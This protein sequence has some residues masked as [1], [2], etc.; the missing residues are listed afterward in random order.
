M[1]DVVVQF[2]IESLEPLRTI[3]VGGEPDGL[4]VTSVL[5][6]A[7]CHACQPEIDRN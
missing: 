1:G 2:A 6:K 5:P 4:A 7:P 3:D